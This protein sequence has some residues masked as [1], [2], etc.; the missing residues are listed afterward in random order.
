MLA[1]WKKSY[2]QPRQ[3]I[4]KQRHYFTTKVHLVKAIVFQVVMYWCERWTIKKV[5]CW[6]TDAFELWYW[7]RLLRVPWT[8]RRSNL[9][10][11]K[12]IS[13][14]YT[15]EGL[16]LKLKF[17]YL[18]SWCEELTHWKRPW[19]WK[20]WRQEEKGTTEDEMV[21]WHHDAIDMS[22]SR[23]WELVTYKE[24][25]SAEVHGVSDLIEWLNLFTCSLPS[26]SERWCCTQ[27]AALNMPANLENS[28]VAIGL[29]KV[30]LHPNSKE[31][32]CQRIFKLPHSCTHLTH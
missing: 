22:L 12:E 1:P 19:Y 32:Q 4:K 5:E 16:M 21:G 6:R 9:P 29:Q 8:P 11:L 24:A 23:L 15:L 7:R 18:A 10:V 27:S 3:H 2:D 28:A 30:S 14:E 13:P 31:G 25:W 26:S 17:H 20:D